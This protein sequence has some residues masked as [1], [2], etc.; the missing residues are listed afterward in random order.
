MSYTPE[1]QPTIEDTAYLIAPQWAKFRLDMLRSFPSPYKN[2]RDSLADGIE[3]AIRQLDQLKPEKNGGP[4]YLGTNPALTIDFE[5][6]KDSYLSPK[7]NT[8]TEVI[9][10]VIKLFEGLPNWGHPLTMCNVNPQGNTAAIVAA[11]LSEIFAPNILEGEYAW[12]THQAE[13]ESGGILA[14]LAGWE[15]K[16]SGCV[17]TYGGSGCWTYHLKYAL[18]RVLPDSRKKGIRTEAKVICSQQAH[19]TMLNSTDWMG[20]G[21]DNI[22]RIKTD[23][24]TNAMDTQH[25]EEV[26]RDCRDK[27]IPVA[28]IVCTMATTDANAFD[29]VQEVRRLLDNYPNPEEYGKVLLYCD[30]VIGWS[31]IAFKNYDF[32]ANPL[33][34]SDAVLPYL[35]KNYNA[36]KGIFYADAFGVDFHKT[37]FS[38]YISSVFVYKNAEE[39]E[40]LLSREVQAYLQ[41][42]SPYN[43]MNYTLEVSRAA[44][45]SMVGWA[46]LKFFGHE[47][48]QSV[49]GGILENKV[50]LQSQIAKKLEMV[51]VNSSDYGLVTLLRIYPA[52]VDA[53]SQFDLELTNP[54]FREELIKHNKLTHAIGDKLFE[55]FRSGKKING[56]H[57]PYLSFSTGF[58]MA[59]YNRDLKDAKAVIYAI[60]MFPM[61]VYITPEVMSH[62]LNCIIAARDEVVLSIDKQSVLTV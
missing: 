45:G 21:M 58:R 41:P 46:T 42:R 51:C 60:K 28:S 18:T 38:P 4:A 5:D 1:E 9:R 16:K 32:K 2:E 39:F 27:E 37:G 17:Y 56:Q 23:V 43:P 53:P 19:Y 50:Y 49:L 29:P 62:A 59:E 13:L 8:S 30:S 33:G 61:N 3:D 48:F 54:D 36:V 52:G 22:I 6:I 24:N 26:L 10:Q 20:L 12:N 7:M 55:W 44:T 31:W 40:S 34:F 47:G 15:P 57:T 25:L 11:V 35:E 14:N